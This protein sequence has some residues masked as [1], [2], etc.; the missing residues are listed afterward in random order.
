MPPRGYAK[1]RHAVAQ[2]YWL[3]GLEANASR[4][5]TF[6]AILVTLQIY[7]AAL[8]RLVGMMARAIVF[9]TSIGVIA[10]L[11][12]FI[13]SGFVLQRP[14]IPD[15]CVA[16]PCSPPSALAT[17]P[18]HPTCFSGRAEQPPSVA[19]GRLHVAVVHGRASTACASK[20]SIHTCN[21]A[22]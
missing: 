15:W 13:G 11:V 12:T 3:V 4:F 18:A 2:V 17:S 10:M 9:G 14:Q 1:S 8:Y 21:A 7:S 5:F 19:E 16:A 6:W 20:I 22:R